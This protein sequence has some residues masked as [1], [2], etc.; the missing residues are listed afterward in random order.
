MSMSGSYLKSKY[1]R[2]G[3]DARLKSGH[4]GFLFFSF[5]PLCG[6]GVFALKKG[7]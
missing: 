7:F 4:D 1:W 3:M 6:F 5:A 2:D